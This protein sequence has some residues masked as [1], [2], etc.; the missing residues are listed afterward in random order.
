MTEHFRSVGGER[1]ET[2][3]PVTADNVISTPILD[4]ALDRLATLSPVQYE[5]ERKSAAKRLN[6]R[7]A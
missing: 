7:D 4:A 5:R 2:L 6:V 1:T 3:E